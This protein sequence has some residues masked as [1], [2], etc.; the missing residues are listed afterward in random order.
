M[1]IPR[2]GV[3]QDGI[4]AFTCICD[5]G[6]QGLLCEINIDDCL[7]NSCQNGGTCVD[8]INDFLC[9][10]RLGFS[11]D[12]CTILDPVC[13]VG[14]PCLNGGICVN[15]EVTENPERFRCDCTPPFSGQTCDFDPRE[16]STN[17]TVVSM[18]DLCIENP[19]LNNGVCFNQ[20]QLGDI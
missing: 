11:G 10:C 2:N 15:V 1:V 17:A 13:D 14:N 16:V 6:Y 12:I 8:L 4:N 19:C 18:Q 20:D 9:N 7:V 5:V 3:C